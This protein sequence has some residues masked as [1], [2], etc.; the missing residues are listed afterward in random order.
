[1]GIDDTLVVTAVIK[2]IGE[3]AGTE[4]VQLY[5]RDLVGSVTRPVKELKGFQRR[6]LQPGE[7]Q[8]VRFAVPVRDLGFT[9]LDTRYA[10]E[11]GAFKVWVGP[12]STEGLEGA[13]E[14]HC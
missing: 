12:N 1:V 11:P 3:R 6:T 5:V 7:E 14:V 13:F 4:V 2:N 8:T 10:V 9:G